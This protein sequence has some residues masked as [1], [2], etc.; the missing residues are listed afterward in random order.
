VIAGERD[1]AER[2]RELA[3]PLRTEV[4]TEHG[5]TALRKRI[6]LPADAAKIARLLRLAKP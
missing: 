2:S 4:G 3:A 5:I 1:P 6:E